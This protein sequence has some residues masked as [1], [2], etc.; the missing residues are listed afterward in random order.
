M[1]PGR[2][3]QR[4]HREALLSEDGESSTAEPGPGRAQDPA[5][6]SPNAFQAGEPRPRVEPEVAQ[7]A[8]LT[9]GPALPRPASGKGQPCSPAYL[10]PQ[11]VP[12]GGPLSRASA[13]G[14]G[15][16]P[17]SAASFGGGFAPEC[18]ICLIAEPLADLVAPCHCTGSLSYAHMHC[19]RTW[20][21]EKRS[22]TCELCST[23]YKEPYGSE[24]AA[25]IPPAPPPP[26]PRRLTT[27]DGQPIIIMPVGVLHHAGQG[28][29]GTATVVGVA[30]PRDLEP[31]PLCEWRNMWSYGLILLLLLFAVIYVTVISKRGRQEPWMMTLW[32]VLLVVLP[33]YLVLRV[34]FDLYR[35]RLA[36]Q[37]AAA[38]LQAV[39]MA[40]AAAD[41]AAV[42]GPGSGAGVPREVIITRAGGRVLVL[43]RTGS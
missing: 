23:M 32:Q 22:V 19:L 14:P 36:Q 38:N 25:S 12:E 18:R 11:P 24:L 26:A 15:L 4:S 17:A 7:P 2:G 27:P 8:A 5:P 16:V 40:N 42:S 6:A 29:G 30:D 37:L 9:S 13:T 43:Q 41:A 20:V 3:G 35:H 21:I 1:P 33:I 34:A 28:S 31:Q 10:T 39:A